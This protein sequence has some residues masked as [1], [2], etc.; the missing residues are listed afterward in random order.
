MY[1]I[2]T[3]LIFLITLLGSTLA[4]G[5]NHLPSQKFLI[6]QD[7]ASCKAAI[8]TTQG[9]TLDRNYQLG[10]KAGWVHCTIAQHGAHYTGFALSD[11][12]ASEVF[13]KYTLLQPTP[14][15]IGGWKSEP[16]KASSGTSASARELELTADKGSPYGCTMGGLAPFEEFIWNHGI[17]EFR[18]YEGTDGFLPSHVLCYLP[19]KN[20]HSERDLVLHHNE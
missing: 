1:R 16:T 11:V 5:L 10:D 2:Q 12:G 6:E 17:R 8:P 15:N 4:V 7:G 9:I 19:A 20:H 3:T 13:V 14:T 18:F